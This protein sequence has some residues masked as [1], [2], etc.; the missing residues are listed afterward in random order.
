MSKF[1]NLLFRMGAFLAGFF[2]ASLIVHVV[3][4]LDHETSWMPFMIELGSA[5]LCWGVVLAV[6]KHK[7]TPWHL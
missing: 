5:F 7:N 4:E 2:I 6:Q 3:L 1:S